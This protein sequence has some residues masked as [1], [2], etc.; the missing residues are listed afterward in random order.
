LATSPQPSVLLKLEKDP[1]IQRVIIE[2]IF[3]V[4]HHF[5]VNTKLLKQLFIAKA[6]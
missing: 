2:G 5:R 1:E 4:T 6:E 3:R